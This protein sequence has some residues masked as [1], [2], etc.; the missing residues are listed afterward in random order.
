ME[1]QF[2]E[3]QENFRKEIKR[4]LA[5][6]IP[7]RWR[8]IRLG[9]W[10]ENDEIFDVTRDF[11]RKLAQ[12]GWLA[13][14]YPSAYGGM[15]ATPVEQAIINEE[16]ALA[17]APTIGTD[18]LTVGWVGPTIMINGTDAQKEKYVGGIG[19]GELVFC[20]GYSEPDAGSDLAGVQTLA[21]EDGDAYVVN[22]QKI[23]TSCAHRADYCWLAARTDPDA[24]K[25][26]GMSMFI[27]D[28]KT[29]GVTIRPLINIH[30]NHH[31]NEVFFDNAR[32]PKENMVG[33]KNLGWYILAT[34]LNYE[35]SGVQLP[36][37]HIR[38]IEGLTQYAKDTP[39]EG[40]V[41]FDNP[42]IRRKLAELTMENEVCRLICYRVISMQSQGKDPAH[43][44]SMSLLFTSEVHRRVANTG[45]EIL[46]QYGQLEKGSRWTA[47]EGTLSKMYIGCL[48]YGIG[49]GTNEVQRNLIALLGLGL[50][51][52]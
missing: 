19:R 29:P 43:E 51:R 9:A 27:V 49:G 20:L 21:V 17:Q 24:P 36:A 33:E 25:H 41:L 39:W 16:K 26:K 40:G 23:F 18:V 14:G 8:E 28:L 10:E 1:F 46:G 34:A 32:V 50:P 47:L 2:T 7:A 3:E 4:W 42:I 48:P 15:D 5:K 12:K 13:P 6:E 35:R 31:F 22:G 11:E 37:E 44:A 52:K 45:M 38:I 30:G